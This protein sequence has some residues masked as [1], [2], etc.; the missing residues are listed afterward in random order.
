MIFATA[1][2]AGLSAAR[3]AFPDV[4]QRRSSWT[5]PLRF[6]DDG[7]FQLSIFEDL[8]FGENAW[9]S[10]GPEQDVH[11]LQV[12]NTVLDNE[13]PDLVVLNGDLITGE[14]TFLENSTLYVDEI[15]GPLVARNLTWASTYGN[16]DNDVNI[17]TALVYAREHLWPNARTAS[18]V[19][20]ASAGV[21][22]YYLPVYG[23]ACA[24]AQ[25][26]TLT[27]DEV[28]DRCVPALLLWF[29]DS[30]SGNYFQE[31]DAAGNKVPRPGWVDQSV[32]DWFRSTQ[33]ALLARYGE[34]SRRRRCADN[35]T[36]LILPSLA[37]VHIPTYASLLLQ[38]E[39]A[40]GYGV[41][42]H[43]EPGINDDYDL[44]PQ[45][46][47]WCADGT[48][49]TSC[50]YGRQDGAFM[51]ALADAARPGTPAAGKPVDQAGL[52]ALFSGHDHGDTWCYRWGDQLPSMDFAGNGLHL[53]FGQH[54]GYGGYGTWIRGSR[55]VRVDEASL[56]AAAAQF[57]RPAVDTWIRLESGEVVGAVSLNATYG[58]D[59]YP[60]TPHE[61]DL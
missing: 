61:M 26:P 51:Q 6:N 13:S 29:F 50:A 28:A 14:N 41:D 53:C 49:S 31:L 18:M 52:V 3:P 1:V 9:D 17:S 22:N 44:A 34:A 7:T 2:F 15:V 45:A 59:E 16:H 25:D 54:S 37:F 21:S 32:V 38:T 20:N 57:V 12:I 39:T 5:A 10:W 23:S 33:A 40:A 11:S 48:Y 24:A 56:R 60:A 35:A 30:R 55:Q 58:T 46:Q 36:A 19:A 43:R 8:H 4:L 27:A 47:N 42:P